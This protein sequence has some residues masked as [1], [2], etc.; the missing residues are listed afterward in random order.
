MRHVWRYIALGIAVYIPILLAT[1][2]LGQLTG[3]VESRVAGLSIQAVDGTL[4]TG[5]AGS[6]RY[7]GAEYGPVSWRLSPAGLL[8]GRLEYRLAL[9]HPDY[10]GAGRVGITPG[11]A[12]IGRDV[13]LQL[14]PDRLISVF[15]PIAVSTAGQLRLELDGFALRDNRMQDV[16]GLLDWRAAQLLAPLQLPLGDVQCALESSADAGLVARIIQGGTLGASGDVTLA[17][18]GRYTLRLLL[19]PGP[20][21]DADT[22]GLLEAMLQ[23]RPDGTFL[24]SESGRLPQ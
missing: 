13:E 12:I 5:R 14:M 21:L 15:S 3:A 6:L 11:G 17:P 8:R 24:I 16:S 23:P 10:H 9:E 1:F 18:D 2:P 4:F 22:R 20:E 19:A 7:Q